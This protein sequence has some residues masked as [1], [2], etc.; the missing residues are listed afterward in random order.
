M[1]LVGK[2]TSMHKN[3]YMSQTRNWEALARMQQLSTKDRLCIGLTKLKRGTHENAGCLG[4]DGCSQL[5]LRDG[6]EGRTPAAA[7]FVCNSLLPPAPPTA[8]DF[9]PRGANARGRLLLVIAGVLPVLSASPLTMAWPSPLELPVCRVRR[10]HPV[11]FRDLPF[12]DETD[13]STLNRSAVTNCSPLK[14]EQR[15]QH[16]NAI[17]TPEQKWL[18]RLL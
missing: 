15:P 18:L 6:F 7:F 4:H 10:L 2:V 17:Q 8:A 16:T 5:F 9:L 11:D 13:P 14:I 3:I 12:F 1:D